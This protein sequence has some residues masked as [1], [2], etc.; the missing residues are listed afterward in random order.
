MVVKGQFVLV[1]LKVARTPEKITFY[2]AMIM[3]N[4]PKKTD[5]V[6]VQFLR[7]TLNSKIISFVYPTLTDIT[8]VAWGVLHSKLRV[9]N[10]R[11]GKYVFADK[12]LEKV[13]ECLSECT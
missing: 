7:K 1:E 6:Q 13:Y 4:T 8:V 3:Q 9:K 11:R 12:L 10:Q 5:K 2:M